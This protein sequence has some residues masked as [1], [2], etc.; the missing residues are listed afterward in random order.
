[1]QIECT[2]NQ[3]VFY[4]CTF[5]LGLASTKPAKSHQI[6]C[7][8]EMGRRQTAKG[9][10]TNEARWRQT[11]A[12]KEYC[13]QNCNQNHVQFYQRIFAGWLPE[14]SIFIFRN[15][16]QDVDFFTKNRIYR[17]IA[18]TNVQRLENEKYRFSQKLLQL[19]YPQGNTL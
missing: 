10:L 11:T 9:K 1:M 7:T 17:L 5:L 3:C 18:T 12:V 6:K 16:L 19:H 2:E 13:S 4:L 8:L 15:I 14:S